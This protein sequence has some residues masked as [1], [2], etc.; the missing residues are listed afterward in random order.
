L[1]VIESQSQKILRYT[2]PDDN[3]LLGKAEVFYDLGGSGGDGCAFD[4]AG[5]LWVADFHRP[6]TGKGR[7]TVLSP[8]AKVLAYL[9]VPSKVVSNIAFGGPGHDEIFCTTGDPPGV[10]H[11]KVGVKGFA[12]HPGNPLPIAR[13]LP[14]TTLRPHADAATLRKIAMTAAGAKLT[15]GKFDEIMTKQLNSYVAELVD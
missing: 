7:I 15:N 14:I 1:Y 9:P 2:V 3:A 8:E 11:A 13:Y 12:G 10:F 6:E 5:N 4:A